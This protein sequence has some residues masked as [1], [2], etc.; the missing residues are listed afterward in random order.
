MAPK[1]NNTW[2][3]KALA[4]AIINTSGASV[5]IEPLD[6]TARWDEVVAQEEE[7]NATEDQTHDDER[8]ATEDEEEEENAPLDLRNNP[9]V[10]QMGSTT[11]SSY[12]KRDLDDVADKNIERAG[13]SSRELKRI[14]SLVYKDVMVAL[15][16]KEGTKLSDAIIAETAEN[17]QNLSTEYHSAISA[18]QRLNSEHDK[19]KETM[20]TVA[21]K[22]TA[23]DQ[24]FIAHEEKINEFH[25]ALTGFGVSY[26]TE[27][28][29]MIKLLDTFQAKFDD[30]A[31]GSDRSSLVRAMEEKKMVS[32]PID[33]P[34]D[35]PKKTLTSQL[36]T[37]RTGTQAVPT[38]S[39]KRYTG[40]K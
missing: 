1:T 2:A 18:F 14:A 16:I 27:H 20:T 22:V 34:R 15:N 29:K 39:K 30:P 24:S 17:F 32:T 28:R 10:I 9:L 7:F 3:D 21:T 33:I 13:L 38:L 37:M 11:E 12:E 36:S 23:H 8:S 26:Q 6:P 25:K 5:S 31:L 35:T 19:M 4:H 40:P